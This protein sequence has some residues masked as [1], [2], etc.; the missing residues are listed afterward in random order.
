MAKQRRLGIILQYAQMAI[1]IVISLLFTPIML[2][3]LGKNEY[4][5]Y[6]LASSIIAYLSLLSLGFGSSY[7]RFYSRYKIN[8]DNNSIRRMNGLYLLVFSFIGLITLIFGFLLAQNAQIF[9]V[10]YIN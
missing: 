3:I 2:R 6:N 10:L 4:G 7:L 9:P 8:E 5:I 1:T